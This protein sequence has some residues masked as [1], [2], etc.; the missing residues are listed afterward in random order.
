MFLCDNGQVCEL[1]KIFASN[2]FDVS[3][4]KQ[5]S[6]SHLTANYEIFHR[7]FSL[8]GG[9]GTYWGNPDL[10]NLDGLRIDDLAHGRPGYFTRKP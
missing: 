4:A 2:D 10:V 1:Q 8:R 7:R 9:E 3:S 5:Y 6:Q